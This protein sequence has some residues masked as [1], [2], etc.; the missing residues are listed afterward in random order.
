MQTLEG[1]DA[2]RQQFGL[3]L[4]VNHQCNLRCSYCYTGA[5]FSFPMPKEIATTAINRA[6]ASL[7]PAGHLNL[8]FFGGE[9]LLES[10]RILEW[11]D[12]A[13]TRARAEA[14]QVRFDLSTNGTI[15]NRDAWSV[16]LADDLDLTVSCDGLPD[17]HDRHRT[18][19]ERRGSAVIVEG[20]L[21]ELAHAGKPVC[22]NSV[23]RPDTLDLLPQGLIY[24]HNMGIRHV[25]LS[26]DL[27][28]SWSIG[29][30][31]RLENMIER[32]AELWHGWLPNFSLN[33]FDAKVGALSNIPHLHEDTRCGFGEG[34][35]A[36]APSGRLYPCERLIGEDPPDARHQLPGQVQG[37][38]ACRVKRFPSGPTRFISMGY[39]LTGP[40]IW[41]R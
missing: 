16:I 24:L 3:T 29:D 32:A 38:S 21:Q 11:M 26:L 30:G 36:V 33:W 25:N 4:M 1:M 34:E 2:T 18:D 13:R 10:V 40:A 6:L 15:K 23:V 17:V 37:W 19:P 41:S 5:K 20:T 28:T 8:S 9:P 7:A 27:W 14:K 35:I 39:R 31:R 12:F 22:V